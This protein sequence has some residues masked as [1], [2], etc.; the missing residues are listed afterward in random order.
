[1]SASSH[2]SGLTGV[3][4]NIVG[5]RDAPYVVSQTEGTAARVDSR[6]TLQWLADITGGS[7]SSMAEK[8]DPEAQAARVLRDLHQTYV[9]RVSN[10][11]PPDGAGISPIEIRVKRPGLTVRARQGYSGDAR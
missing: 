4:I 11:P 5:A 6:T 7:F 3:S 2:T 10:A 9:L 1:M 8:I